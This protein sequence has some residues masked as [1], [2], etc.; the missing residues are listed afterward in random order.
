MHQNFTQQNPPIKPR[1]YAT[2]TIA[3]MEFPNIQCFGCNQMGHYQNRCPKRTDRV[4]IA[5]AEA[6]NL[7]RGTA[8]QQRGQG[9]N[10]GRGRGRAA[11]MHDR[12][13]GQAA[14][15]NAI[16]GEPTLAEEEGD[17]VVYHPEI[18]PSN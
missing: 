1:V 4:A 16:I 13:R 5:I 6:P 8:N 14:H 10:H 9:G 17:R 3:I 18:I 2:Q 12:G 7:G 11:K 15:V